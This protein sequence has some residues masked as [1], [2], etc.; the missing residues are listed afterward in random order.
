MFV[1]T[2]LAQGE[3][4]EVTHSVQNAMWVCMSNALNNWTMQQREEK[5]NSKTLLT[6]EFCAVVY[7]IA[8]V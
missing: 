8:A 3:E 2:D 5:N 7:K 6:F 4:N 1:Q